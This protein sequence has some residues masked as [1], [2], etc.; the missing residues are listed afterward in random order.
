LHFSLEPSL[1]S[2][3]LGIANHD[4][5][6]LIDERSESRFI[7]FAG[8]WGND[9]PKWR[10]RGGAGLCLGVFPDQ[11]VGIPPFHEVGGHAGCRDVNLKLAAQE[12]S[13][14]GAHSLSVPAGSHPEHCRPAIPAERKCGS[15]GGKHN[16]R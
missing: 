8:P 5:V 10:K 6:Y 11:E 13:R 1:E 16:D 3:D 14:Y 7:L 2:V 4:S 12:V 15:Y 9:L